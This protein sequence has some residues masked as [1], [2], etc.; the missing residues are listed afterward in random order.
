MVEWLGYEVG[1]ILQGLTSS[2]FYPALDHASNGLK[3]LS[4][5]GTRH[6]VKIIVIFIR[7]GL[8]HCKK[9]LKFLSGMDQASISIIRGPCIGEYCIR[10]FV[11][12]FLRLT[13]FSSWR[14]GACSDKSTWRTATTSGTWWSSKHNSNLITTWVVDPLIGSLKKVLVRISRCGVACEQIRRSRLGWGCAPI[15]K[16]ILGD[17]GCSVLPFVVFSNILNLLWKWS[18]L[19]EFWWPSLPAWRKYPRAPSWN[20][21][22]ASQPFRQPWSPLISRT[23]IT[24]QQGTASPRRL[25]RGTVVVRIFWA[26]RIREWI[27]TERFSQLQRQHGFH[28]HRFGR[29]WF[30]NPVL[31][32]R[33]RF[34]IEGLCDLLSP[35]KFHIW[36]FYNPSRLS[37]ASRQ[38][39]FILYIL[40]T[41]LMLLLLNFSGNGRI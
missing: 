34:D 18:F 22:R 5:H 16:R 11:Q 23:H 27:L 25:W 28:S 30:L 2:D 20:R 21:G 41:L 4:G 6:W 31:V 24:L 7:T 1:L 33:I 13:V 36:L 35:F 37:L 12:P 39:L 3:F 8:D 10:T 9:F 26:S 38:V 14:I 29:R 19:L 17:L 40:S 15:K 32:C